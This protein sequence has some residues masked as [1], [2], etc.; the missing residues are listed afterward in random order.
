[1]VADLAVV[2]EAES[3]AFGETIKVAVYGEYGSHKTLQIRHLINAFGADKVA[4]ISVER[5]LNTVRSSIKP[6]NV[7]V[8]DSL[9]TMRGAWAWADK[10]FNA[11]DKWVCIDGGSRMMQLL[12]NE[13][14]SGAERVFERKAKGLDIR[15]ADVPFSRYLTDKGNIET[16]QIYGRIGRDAE[17]VLNSWLRLKSN[18]YVNYL[19]DLTGSNGREKTYPFGPDVPGRVG[20]K[21]VMS[22]FD[23]VL[24]LGLDD[25]GKLIART[26]PTP[27][28]LARTR[29][30]RDTGVSIPA[31]MVNFN[32][33]SFVRA[34]QGGLH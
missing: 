24:H 26:R 23:F 8:A 33:A 18:L 5:G 22:S 15:A 28:Y 21:A 9:E 7:Y 30:D 11:G 19:Q 29:E 16:Q 3:P 1:M 31:E 2:A 27:M 10:N 32:L 13:Q 14:F 17:N 20:L 12:A 4:V 25:A 34:I 6:D